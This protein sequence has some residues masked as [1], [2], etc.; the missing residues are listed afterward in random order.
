ML[1]RELGD[2]V[3]TFES[4]I[5]LGR[6][7][8]VQGDDAAARTLFEETLTL[9]REIGD[10]LC[11]ASCLEGLAD[12][13]TIQGELRWAAQL[14]GAAESLHET[15]GAPILPVYRAEYEQAVA[16]ARAQLGEKAFAA[17]WAEGRKMTPELALTAQG[18][19]TVPTPG[20]N[21]PPAPPAKAPTYP[22]ELTAREVDVLRLLA[23]GLTSAQIAEQLI[24]SLLTVNTHVRSI[25]SKLGVTSR[26]AATRWAVEHH[27]V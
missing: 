23:Q 17:A 14:W 18:Q 27:L 20:S 10:R 9:A 7:A 13:A 21:V 26:S 6:V 22:N 5:L 11:T 8:V 3:D 4:L 24:L 12:V 2:T 15:M 16:T 1:S 25:Y 19:A